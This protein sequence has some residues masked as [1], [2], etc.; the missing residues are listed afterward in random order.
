MSP[1]RHPNLA[2]SD[3]YH[4]TSN[5]VKKGAGLS[6]IDG[7]RHVS[8]H[9]FHRLLKIEEARS[10][11]P[12]ENAEDSSLPTDNSDCLPSSDVFDE[13]LPTSDGSDC[14]TVSTRVIDTEDSHSKDENFSLE[15]HKGLVENQRAVLH[16]GEEQGQTP[17]ERS[18]PAGTGAMGQLYKESVLL[19]VRNVYE[20]S[21]GH[22]RYAFVSLVTRNFNGLHYDVVLFAILSVVLEVP[23][24]RD[25][26]FSGWLSWWR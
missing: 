8:P 25:L 9:E 19:D 17:G 1:T 21:I 4:P 20:T 5:N 12:Y 6:H 14:H 13:P 7:G 23:S 26:H 16:C 18:M 11:G 10:R 3:P 24:P 22:F 15:A 2:H